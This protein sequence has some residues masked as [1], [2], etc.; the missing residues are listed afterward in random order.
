VPFFIAG[1]LPR[2][3]GKVNQNTQP[4]ATLA[5]TLNSPRWNSTIER[6]M[7]KPIPIPSGLVE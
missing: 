6:Q 2:C 3:K 4:P 7:F 5:L 1:T